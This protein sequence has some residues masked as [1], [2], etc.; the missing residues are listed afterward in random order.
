[1]STTR[2]SLWRTRRRGRGACHAHQRVP[3]A[4]PYSRST[5]PAAPE[6]LNRPWPLTG[7]QEDLDAVVAA[8]EQGCPALFIVGEA[9]TGKT[10]LAREALARLRAEGWAVAGATATE[11]SPPRRSAR[12]PTSCQRAPTHR[13]QRSSRQPARDRR[14]RRRPSPRAPRGRRPPPRPHLGEPPREPGRVGTVRPLLT[15]RSGLAVPEAVT[16]LRSAHDV[17]V[18]TSVHSMPS[19]S[20]RSCIGCSA[21]PSTGWPQHA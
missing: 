4:Q 7:R 5:M 13:R 18:L 10:R 1:M 21:V 16:A 6:G 12:S 17:Q 11:T 14:R 15:M 8:V 2:A 3:L 9:G 20:T 19:P